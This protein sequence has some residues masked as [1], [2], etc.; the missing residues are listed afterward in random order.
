MQGVDISTRPSGTCTILQVHLGTA[1]PRARRPATMAQR[2][3][4][5]VCDRHVT[6]PKWC[7]VIS[8]SECAGWKRQC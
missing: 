4:G 5:I 6:G 7:W 2:L 8:T 3:D 1:A